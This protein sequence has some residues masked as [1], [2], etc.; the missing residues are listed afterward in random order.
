[1]TTWFTSPEDPSSRDARGALVRVLSTDRGRTAGAGVYLAGRRL[2]TCAHVINAALGLRS[3]SPHNPGKV[4][5]DVSFPVLS[6]SDVHP[7]RLVAWIPPRSPQYGPV[8]DGSLE[9]DGDLAVLELNDEPPPPVSPVRWLEME[10]GQQVRAW[11]GGGQP[12]SYADARVGAYDG[13]ICY[14][15]G[16][17]SGAAVDEGYSGGPLWSV[18]D[19]A[20]VGLVMGRITAPDGALSAQHTVRRSWGLG[21]QSVF[22]ELA[23]VG[24]A[25]EG[26]V[27][28]SR[29]RSAATLAEAESVRDMMVG[30]L[31]GLLGDPRARAD[32]ATVLAAQLGL[33]APADGSAPTVEEL[34]LLLSGTERALPTLAESLAPKVTDDSRGRAELDRLLALGRLTEAARLLSVPEHRAL[35]GK[36]EYLTEHDPGLLCRAATAALPY[37]DLPRSLQAARLVPSAVPGVVRELESWYGDGSPVP[38]ETPRLPALLRVVEYVAAET[39]GDLAR[40]A[41]REWSSRV[42]TRLGIH[43]SA[44]QER[45]GDADRWSRRTAPAGVRVLVELDRYAKDPVGHYRCSVWRLRPDGTPAR[46]A[47]ESDRPRTGREIARLIREVAGGAEGA[48]GGVALVAVSVPPDALELALDEWDGAGADEYIPAPLGEDFHLV[49]RCPKIRRRSRTGHADLERRWNSRHQSDTLLADHRIG[50]RAGLIGLLKTTHRD[51]ARVLVH[52]STELRGELLPVCLVM[53]VPVVLWDRAAPGPDDSDPLDSLAP[54]GPVDG[55]P[56]RVRHF[57]VHAYANRAVS[58]RPALVWEDIGL[59]LPD[60]LQLADPSEGTERTG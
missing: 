15:D 33:R 35:V 11:Y 43:S 55:L 22:R 3:L 19:Q 54:H 2:L 20:A 47:T 60:E 56:E 31:H 17:L 40:Q 9:W 29:E 42:A 49:L 57:R 41:L 52:G 34:A 46:A 7:A 16:Q 14:L 48:G 51:T 53:G 5:L 30:P 59:P 13:R 24:A 4:T 18:T 32:H 38:D 44:L 36:L 37:V 6:A 26:H 8:P 58:A 28:G 45:R 50:G 23:R 27:N 10:R 12:F 25:P 21:W 1:M 39:S